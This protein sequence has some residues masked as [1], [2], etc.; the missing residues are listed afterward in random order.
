MIC[1]PVC[2]T[3]CL[4]PFSPVALTSESSLPTPSSELGVTDKVAWKNIDVMDRTRNT[5]SVVLLQSLVRLR[6]FK[7]RQR[8]IDLEQR[9][10]L[11]IASCDVYSTTTVF[12]N[13]TW[14]ARR[15]SRDTLHT[16]S[17]TILLTWIGLTIRLVTR[18]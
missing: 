14:Q 2:P 11:L 5:F 12:W 17:K 8:Q 13:N 18:L 3:E 10:L 15:H 6:Y 16:L 7:C 4:V 9:C 1:P